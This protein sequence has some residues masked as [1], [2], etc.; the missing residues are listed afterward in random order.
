MK[1][2]NP[3]LTEII[4]QCFD[5]SMDGRVSPADQTEFL[6]IGKRL[7]G[8]LLNLLSANFNDGT[9]AVLDANQ[10]IDDLNKDLANSAQVLANAATTLNELDQLVGILDG[11][12][13]L[14]SG[15]K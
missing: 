14:A 13:K 10:S 6:A 2:N 1:T 12:L 3:G 15:F 9:K 5:Y 7:R 4:D 11:L 8:S